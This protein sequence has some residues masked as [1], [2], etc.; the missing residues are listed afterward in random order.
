MVEKVE[1]VLETY[2]GSGERTEEGREDKER[3]GK[4]R[5]WEKDG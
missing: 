3:V 5:K 4:R 1:D 2:C